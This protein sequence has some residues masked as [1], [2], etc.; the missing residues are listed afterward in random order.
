MELHLIGKVWKQK[1]TKL[2]TITNPFS[3]HYTGIRTINTFFTPNTIIHFTLKTS[4]HTKNNFRPR[5]LLYVI[6][7]QDFTSDSVSHLFINN[8]CIRKILSLKGLVKEF[9][10]F[11]TSISYCISYGKSLM[12]TLFPYTCKN[13][14]VHFIEK[15]NLLFR[16][17][18]KTRFFAWKMLQTTTI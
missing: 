4:L 13:I 8:R 18:N 1:N 7:I 16:P 17:D 9:H 15:I 10:T 2:I 6:C 14:F 3:R 12:K 5:S 11:K